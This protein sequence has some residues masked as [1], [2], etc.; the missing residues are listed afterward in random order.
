MGK[1]A[2]ITDSIANPPQEIIKRYG[3]Q[4]LPINIL[5]NGK[6]Y[7]DGIELSTA[8]AYRI[9]EEQPEHFYSAPASVG[10]YLEIFKQTAKIADG[11]LCITLSSKLSTVHN[12]A[13]LA[14]IQAQEEGLTIP[15]NI[16][17]SRTVVNAEG[18]VVTAA[19]RAAD[20]GKSLDEV[21]TIAEKVKERVSLIG[22]L[23]TVQY[24]YRTGRIPKF[25]STVGSLLNIKPCFSISEGIVHLDGMIKNQ[26]SGIKHILKQLSKKIKDKPAHISVAHSSAPEAGKSLRDAIQTKFNCT[27][28]WLTDLSPVVAY[29]TGTGVL[30]AAYYLD[31]E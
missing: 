5:F 27:E 25:T 15:I 8:Q 2:I 23:D 7:R 20:A 24:V 30:I 9:L 28:L 26:D 16:L 6:K 3:I 19:A 11:I 29:A 10:E 17:D 14:K 12:N 1:V 22:I 13:R 31:Q 18:L 21:T 4:I